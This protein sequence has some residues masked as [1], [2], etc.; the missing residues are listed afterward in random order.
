MPYA[1][2]SPATP[3]PVLSGRESDIGALTVHRLLPQRARRLVGPFVFFDHMGPADIAPGGGIDVRP[4]PHIG[5]ATVTYLFAG[6]ILHHDSLGCRQEITP[7]A[8]NWMVAGRGIVHSER[9][10][11]ED[12]QSGQFLDGIQT[13]VALPREAEETEPAF[14]HHAAE[15]LPQVER[16]GARCTLILGSAYGREAPAQVFSPLFYV[17]AVMPAGAVL[18]LPEEHAERA[19]YVAEGEVTVDGQAVAPGTMLLV[20]GPEPPPVTAERDARVVLLGGAPLP[21][22]RYV[23]WNFVSS[24]R[25]RIEQAKADRRGGRFDAVPG[26]ADFIPL[27]E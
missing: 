21:E 26:E 3:R 20:D 25:E 8:V 7:G 4:H 24:R 17:D 14:V 2:A 5:L 9:T 23:W 12:R 18:D 1:S 11:P 19:V 10:M 16:G 15:T 22:P 13:W 27:P 6:R